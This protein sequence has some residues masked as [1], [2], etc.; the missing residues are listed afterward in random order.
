MRNILSDLGVL[1][2]FLCVLLKLKRIQIFCS[3]MLEFWCKN[4]GKGRK[5]ACAEINFN[6]VPA[7]EWLGEGVG[8]GLEQR[9][10]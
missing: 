1:L 7:S 3:R 8:E 9:K 2:D 5:R 4:T 6:P 10:G